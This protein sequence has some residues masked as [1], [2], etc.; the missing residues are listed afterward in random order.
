LD[1]RVDCEKGVVGDVN[2]AEVFVP[3]L[4]FGN[5]VV[6]CGGGRFV[7]LAGVATLAAERAMYVSTHFAITHESVQGMTANSA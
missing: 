3:P 7:V 6:S 2:P 5:A 4:L 1:G